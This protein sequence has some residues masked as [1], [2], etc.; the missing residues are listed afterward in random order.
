MR[1]FY[2]ACKTIHELHIKSNAI[3]VYYDLCS[4]ANK[5]DKC[6]PS[7]KTISKA[8]SVSVSTVTRSLRELENAGMI[9][10]V[11]RY[12]HTN[13]RQTSNIYQ[14]FDTPQQFTQLPEELNDL[15]ANNVEKEEITSEIPALENPASCMQDES[16]E[17]ELLQTPPE[18]LVSATTVYSQSNKSDIVD[19][20]EACIT[21][22][23][24]ASVITA[25]NYSELSSINLFLCFLRTFFDTLPH[26]SMTPQGTI[27]RTKVT[28]NLRKEAIFSK[29]T[30]WHKGR[31]DE[32]SAGLR[33]RTAKN[34]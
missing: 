29:V 25:P 20:T 23:E 18:A 31:Q 30:K 22:K 8:C 10:T 2:L 11:A 27:P 26:V 9:T 15:P 7:K 4:R 34:E 21:A 3:L 6:W 33:Y 17:E 13:N 1:N 5:E 19:L 12:R 28:D 14:I 16:V 32:N 24:S